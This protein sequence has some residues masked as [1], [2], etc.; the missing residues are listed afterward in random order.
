MKEYLRSLGFTWSGAGVETYAKVSEGA[1]GEGVAGGMGVYLK[2]LTFLSSAE[3]EIDAAEVN[4]W[5][6]SQDDLKDDKLWNF[7]YGE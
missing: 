2:L 6:P 1:F 5:M 3:G 7:H 4:A